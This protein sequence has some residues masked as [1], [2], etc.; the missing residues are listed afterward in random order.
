M[1]VAEF[2]WW[3]SVKSRGINMMTLD[4]A[5]TQLHQLPAIPAVVQEVVA[6]FS[7]PDVDI[8]KLA[9]KIGQD[10]AL[11]A[12]ILRVSNSSF[13]GFPR[14]IASLHDAVVIMGFAGVR[15]LVL[16]TGFIH[17]FEQASAGTLNRAEYWKRSLR[18]ATYAKAVAR[19]L[20]QSPEIAFT[21]GLLH[22]I[23]QLVLDTCLPE[24][25]Q[26]AIVK[27]QAENIDLMTAEAAVLGFHHDTLGAEVARRWN[28]PVVIEQAIRDCHSADM[29]ALEPMSVVVCLAVRLDQGDF[30][31]T[32]FT[33][34][35]VANQELLGPE[36]SRLIPMLPDEEKLEAAAASL[37]G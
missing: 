28:F 4:E 14:K 10:Q 24:Q 35:S 19:C 23:G 25:Y 8:D 31:A 22:D 32:L 12:K 17:A 34:I 2:C 21:A 11:T 20:K 13:Y 6:S 5:L 37:L 26:Q 27:A 36:A 33:Q 29:R 7:Q 15:S 9:G 1:R 3:S 30:P 16:S 18:V